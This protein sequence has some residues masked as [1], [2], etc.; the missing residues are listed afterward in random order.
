VYGAK[1][2]STGRNRSWRLPETIVE[3]TCAGYFSHPDN[4]FGNNF[5]VNTIIYNAILTAG[6]FAP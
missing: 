5:W 6:I 4:F 3:D 1:I 2:L